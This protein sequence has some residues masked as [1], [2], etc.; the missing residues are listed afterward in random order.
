MVDY[1]VFFAFILAGFYCF[2]K[3]GYS[4]GYIDAT[5]SAEKIIDEVFYDGKQ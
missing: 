3:V 5:I 1:I 2:Y 4:E